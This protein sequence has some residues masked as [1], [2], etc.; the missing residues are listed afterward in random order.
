MATKK[1]VSN[2]EEVV[3]PSGEKMTL[4][5]APTSTDPGQQLVE[6]T[7]D[8]MVDLVFPNSTREGGQKLVAPAGHVTTRRQAEEMGLT[9]GQYKEIK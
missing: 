6:V 8:V 9:S 3:G 2:S 1:A 5:V 4:Q 7:E